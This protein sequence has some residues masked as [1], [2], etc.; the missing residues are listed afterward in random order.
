MRC[1]AGVEYRRRTSCTAAAGV[2]HS[3]WYA[4]RWKWRRTPSE[5]DH[6]D[7]RQP[8]H[9]S[10]RGEPGADPGG[11]SDNQCRRKVD[12]AR[13]VGLPTKFFVVLF[14]A[15]AESRCDVGCDIGNGDEWGIVHLDAVNHGKIR[16][17]RVWIGVGHLGG[18]NAEELTGWETP[19]QTR[20]L[21]KTVEETRT[22]VTRL[23]DAGADQI[24]F[25]DGNNFTPE[26]VKAGCDLAHA[27]NKPCTQRTGGKMSPAAGAMA[28]VD[29]IPHASG[30]GAAIQKDGSTITGGD[31]DRYA[32]MDDA[33][34]KALIDILVRED[35]RPVPNIIHI[36]PIYPRDLARFESHLAAA[37]QD[38]GLLD[39]YPA[40]F[41]HDQHP[42]R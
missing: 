7:S 11:C 33:K 26:M 23:L 38:P 6:C 18:V 41:F 15:P 10:R 8:D 16:G 21:P 42:Y 20:Q 22:V 37:F 3:G 27:R 39:Y 17:S 34:A 29:M 4:D 35:V 25:H 40:A 28:G 1:T 19:L 12:R 13:I 36:F 2:G 30:I 9:R 31:L 32:D 24:M 14:R 5:F